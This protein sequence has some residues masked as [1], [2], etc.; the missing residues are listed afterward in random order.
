MKFF[1]IFTKAPQHQRF[2]FKPRYYDPQREEMQE[3]ENRIRIKLAREQGNLSDNPAIHRTRI[4][5]AFQAA[6]RRSNPSQSGQT[7]LIRLGALLFISVFL[8]AFITWGKVVLYSL[9][10]FLPVY[11][12]LRFR[13]R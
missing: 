6:R 9:F 1:S 12:F 3:R 5:G 8:I 4:A 2:Q 10:L 13:T 11:F 7:V